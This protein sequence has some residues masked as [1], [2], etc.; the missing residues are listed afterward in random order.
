LGATGIAVATLAWRRSRFLAWMGGLSAVGLVVA[1][2]ATSRII[3]PFEPYLFYWTEALALPAI[4]A[5]VSLIT[6]A[7]WKVLSRPR[8]QRLHARLRDPS[9]PAGSG[10]GVAALLAAGIFIL[11]VVV[12][13]S[14]VSYGDSPQA[15][16]A[17]QVI[18]TAVGKSRRQVFTVEVVQPAFAD[19]PLLLELAK[20][21]YR[22][23][24]APPVDLYTGTTSAPPSGPTFVVQVM[25]GPAALP[26]HHLATIGQ[27]DLWV[28]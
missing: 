28:R 14:A 5:A 16:R 11:P 20:A 27:I 3:G 18:E 12:G 19:G 9:G 2:I 7:G 15:R 21:G 13:A 4:I 22:F 1:G 24:V 25:P 23:H 10:I 17:A 26:G 6:A 8:I